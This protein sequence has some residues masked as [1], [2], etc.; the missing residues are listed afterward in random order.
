MKATVRQGAVY[1]VFLFL[2]GWLLL[3]GAQ[4]GLTL[5]KEA[6]ETYEMRTYHAF[7]ALFPIGAGMLFAVPEVM[8][9]FWREGRWKINWLKLL[10]VGLPLAYLTGGSLQ[11]LTG[12][13]LLPFSDFFTGGYGTLQGLTIST[14]C[15]TAFGYTLLSS[16]R[17]QPG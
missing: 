1:A 5:E 14:I 2:A 3:S 9:D 12:A 8:L 16:V 7:L 4:F 6:A 17:K 10:I 11:F 13:N 15:A